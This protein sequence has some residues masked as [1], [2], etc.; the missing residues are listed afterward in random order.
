MLGYQCLFFSNRCCLFEM[1]EFENKKSRLL[2]RFY[3]WFIFSE[4]KLEVESNYKVADKKRSIRKVGLSFKPLICKSDFVSVTCIMWIIDTLNL[5]V[6]ISVKANARI[7]KLYEFFN[8]VRLRRITA[9]TRAFP[10]N[11]REAIIPNVTL[12]VVREWSIL[13]LLTAGSIL[14]L[15]TAGCV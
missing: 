4:W 6:N 12:K 14:L 9:Q 2:R 15:F 11:A 10:N 1:S 3:Y 7:I 5:P 8:I 13:L